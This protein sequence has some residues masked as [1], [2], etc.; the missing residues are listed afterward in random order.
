MTSNNL[1][2]I[3]LQLLN[4]RDNTVMKLFSFAFLRLLNMYPLKLLIG[5]E[6]ADLT[7]HPPPE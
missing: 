3:S 7:V 2:V 5:Y 1:F 4:F 6:P